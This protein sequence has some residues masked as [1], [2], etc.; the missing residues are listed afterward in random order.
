[1]ETLSA[2]PYTELKRLNDDEQY[3]EDF[4]M[5]LPDYIAQCRKKDNVE[6]KTL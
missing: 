2:L 6:D 4:R 3:N 5:T 1:M